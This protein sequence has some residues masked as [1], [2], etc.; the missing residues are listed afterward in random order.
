[1]LRSAVR[2]ERSPSVRAMGLNVN[3]AAFDLEQ[4]D[5]MSDKAVLETGRDLVNLFKHILRTRPATASNL[6]KALDGLRR[7]NIVHADIKERHKRWQL[8]EES[9]LWKQEVTFA[10]AVEKEEE[11]APTPAVAT[12][13]LP[14]FVL[15]N[16]FYPEGET[17]LHVFEPRYRTMMRDVAEADECFGYIFSDGAGRVASVGTLCQVVFREVLD[18]GRQAIR[19]RGIGRFR[20]REVLKAPQAYTVAEVET[21]IADVPLPDTLHNAAASAQ[22]EKVISLSPTCVVLLS[23]TLTRA[24]FRTR[25]RR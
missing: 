3:I 5:V 4:N 24:L 25:G 17:W 16:C 20:V 6:D 8:R 22:L 13:S 7:L 21:G 11:N 15:G 14:L 2:F 19:V 23:P 10:D 9:P 18:D 1:M 12:R